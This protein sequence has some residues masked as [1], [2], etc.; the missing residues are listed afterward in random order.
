MIRQVLFVCRNNNK[1]STERESTLSLYFIDK[2]VILYYTL[3]FR[4]YIKRVMNE[5]LLLKTD[6]SFRNISCNISILNNSY[7]AN[8]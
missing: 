3:N 7:R 1:Y 5:L 8:N 6:Q 4:F 2:V